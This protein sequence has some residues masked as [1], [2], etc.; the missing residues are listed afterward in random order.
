MIQFSH[1][2]QL[3]RI[4][5]AR[6]QICDGLHD[7]NHGGIIRIGLESLQ[8]NKLEE[9]NGRRH[10]RFLSP[11]CKPWSPL[12]WLHLL[13]SMQHICGTLDRRSKVSLAL[14]TRQSLRPV[15]ANKA[16]VPIQTAKQI[17]PYACKAGN[18]TYL[19]L[20]QTSS[21]GHDSRRQY[22]VC[23]NRFDESLHIWCET[24]RHD[25]ASGKD[26][27]LIWDAWFTSFIKHDFY[28]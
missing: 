15:Q 23:E 24:E 27:C 14:I 18:S 28:A 13:C 8:I 2:R 20:C 9:G 1:F 11:T 7:G 4:R 17:L 21:D 6:Y 10:V 5:S 26:R 22:T 12:L 16:A 25:I 3:Q 19:W